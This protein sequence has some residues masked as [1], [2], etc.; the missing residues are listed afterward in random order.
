[1]IK[2]MT[3]RDAHLE[4]CYSK[5]L[6]FADT[7][8]DLWRIFAKECLRLAMDKQAM[9]AFA[10]PTGWSPKPWAL[11][12]E[13]FPEYFFGDEEGNL[14]LLGAQQLM[15]VAKFCKL[16]LEKCSSLHERWVA[17]ARNWN[18]DYVNEQVALSSARKREGS[19]VN[20]EGDV[21]YKDKVVEAKLEEELEIEPGKYVIRMRRLKD[22]KEKQ[23]G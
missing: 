4:E 20:I 14:E 1:M 7:M 21:T 8:T 3:P 5:G 2:S 13:R 23:D 12:A 6:M 15:T 22:K 9:R 11:A 19:R 17:D 18:L 16:P 10:E